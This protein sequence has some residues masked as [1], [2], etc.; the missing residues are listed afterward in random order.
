MAAP[1]LTGMNGN[2]ILSAV[3]TATT[4]SF[5][6]NAKFSN[7]SMTRNVNGNMDT[8]VDFESDGVVTVTGFTATVGAQVEIAGYGGQ[9]EL[10]EGTV[11]TTAAFL[12]SFGEWSASIAGDTSPYSVFGSQWK[13][14]GL[15][16]FQL[17][18]SAAGVATGGQI[19][20]V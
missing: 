14:T 7:I 19:I 6:F 12:I 1:D 9:A 20:P 16:T 5:S 10:F 8:T 4:D 13:K 18:G 3:T 17:T 2:V 11:T 15:G